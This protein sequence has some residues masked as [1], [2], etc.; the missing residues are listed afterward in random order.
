MSSE[1]EAPRK[2]ESR[3]STEKSIVKRK[4]DHSIESKMPIPTSWQNVRGREP[5]TDILKTTGGRW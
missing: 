3:H 4:Y 5:A 1:P 2:V